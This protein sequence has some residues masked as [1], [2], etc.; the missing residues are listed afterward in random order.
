MRCTRCAT[1]G[2]T[3][4]DESELLEAAASFQ[5]EAHRAQASASAR[6]YADTHYGDPAALVR[7]LARA[8]GPGGPGYRQ[9][10]SA[11]H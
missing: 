1:G 2:A 11:I 7:R 3:F 4:L 10:D 9:A 6:R 8:P 5:S